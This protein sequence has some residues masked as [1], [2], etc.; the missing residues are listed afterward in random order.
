MMRD[1]FKIEFALEGESFARRDPNVMGLFPTTMTGNVYGGNEVSAHLGLNVGLTADLYWATGFDRRDSYG[2]D[3]VMSG[4]DLKIKL[5]T[6]DLSK[7]S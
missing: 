5:S 3:P 4:H 2:G 1:T 6:G 7:L